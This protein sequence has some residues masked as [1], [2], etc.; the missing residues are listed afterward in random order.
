MST[1][2]VLQHAAA[3]VGE[4]PVWDA[5]T[6]TLHWVDILSG[7]AHALRS[8]GSTDSFH[9]D[10]H[11]AGVLPTE[12]RGTLRRRRGASTGDFQARVR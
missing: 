1:V 11:L 8:D 12:D 7:T 5:R 3:V 4:G 9:V 2:E 10:G 6:Q